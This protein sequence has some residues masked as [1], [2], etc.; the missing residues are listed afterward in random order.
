MSWVLIMIPQ[1]P[2]QG[3]WAPQLIETR[4][5]T[6]GLGFPDPSAPALI[7]FSSFPAGFGV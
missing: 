6:P 4:R 2:E 5:Q 7:P 1:V 3:P